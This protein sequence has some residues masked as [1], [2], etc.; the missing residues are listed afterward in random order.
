MKKSSIRLIAAFLVVFSLCATIHLNTRS[1][2]LSV[3]QA[4]I[5]KVLPKDTPTESILPEVHI[6]KTILQKFIPF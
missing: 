5:L 4:E 6:V 1:S 2:D 3:S